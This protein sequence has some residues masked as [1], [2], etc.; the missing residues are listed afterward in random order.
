MNGIGITVYDTVVNIVGGI[1]SSSMLP[2]LCLTGSEGAAAGSIMSIYIFP[3]LLA[4]NVNGDKSALYE[5]ILWLIP[6]YFTHSSTAFILVSLNVV[7]YTYL[8]L[9]QS[10]RKPAHLQKLIFAVL[11]LLGL[12]IFVSLGFL[13]EDILDEINYLLFEKLTDSNNGSTISRS[14]PL[15]VNWGVFTEMPILGVGNGLQGYFFNDYFPMWTL[16]V[17]GSDV[18]QFYDIAQTGIVNGGVFWGG[19]FSGYGIVGLI[20]AFTYIRKLWRT[21]KKRTNAMGIFNDVFLIAIPAFFISGFQGELYAAFYVWFIVAL[22]FMNY[23][24]KDYTLKCGMK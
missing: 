19:Y 2:K 5:F 15:I 7:V 13:G 8:M 12:S 17:E 3:Y 20:L 10:V 14:I 18:G 9:K 24:F 22:P 1:N 21:R 16:F 11:I 4:R 6:L 23:N